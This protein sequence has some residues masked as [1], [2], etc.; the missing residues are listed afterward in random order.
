MK[1]LEDID[2]QRTN[3]RTGVVA[4]TTMLPVVMLCKSSQFIRIDFGAN[5]HTLH[6]L[7]LLAREND[8]ALPY[9]LGRGRGYKLIPN[10]MGVREIQLHVCKRYPNHIPKCANA[11]TVYVTPPLVNI[12]QIQQPT[13]L[14][15]KNVSSTFR[16]LTNCR[17]FLLGNM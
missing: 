11:V 6:M 9:N 17:T 12:A 1:V 16:A 7:K 10:A 13:L 5:I 3:G 15:I 2:K 4:R 14:T 8:S